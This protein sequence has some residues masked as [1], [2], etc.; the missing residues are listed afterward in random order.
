[1]KR[2]LT[3][4]LTAGLLSALSAVALLAK[5]K[6]I[7]REAEKKA[8]PDMQVTEGIADKNIVEAYKRLAA[9]GPLVNLAHDDR[10]KYFKE[11]QEPTDFRHTLRNIVYTPRNTY[12]RYVKES[13]EFLLVGLGDPA[14]T[15]AKITEKVTEASNAGVQVA[16]P[17]FQGREGIELTQFEFVYSEDQSG[18]EAV[19]SRRKSV[20]L[21]YKR[22]A[23]GAVDTEQDYTLDLVV[24]RIVEDDYK[25]GVKDVEV[26]IDATP[27]TENMDDV[28]VVHRYNQKPS[29]TIVIGAMPNTPIFPQRLAFKQ[30]FYV[31]LLD[32]YNILYRLVDGYA[33]RDGNSFQDAVLERLRA[34]TEY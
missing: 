3:I 15:Q 32:H 27:G 30:K 25:K 24:T 6:I 19:G 17:A 21:F 12:V 33:K 9:F 1:M 7:D 31:R 28:I 4:S 14:E 18:R 16:A 22:A 13:P 5:P 34:S 20:S 8:Y 23:Q 26:V 2:I 29:Q 10:E 11:R